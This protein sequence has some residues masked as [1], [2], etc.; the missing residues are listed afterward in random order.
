MR[1]LAASLLVALA[2][3][4]AASAQ[5]PDRPARLAPAPITDASSSRCGSCHEAAYAAWEPS[6]HHRSHTDVLF[7]RELRT[8]R[9]P[10]W[11]SGCHAPL[12]RTPDDGAAREEGVGCSVC[13]VRDGVVLARTVSGRAPH[14]SEVAA[15]DATRACA[16][17]HQFHFAPSS[18]AAIDPALWLQDTVGE[19]AESPFAQRTCASCHLSSQHG[20]PHALPGHTDPSLLAH[21]LRVE[22]TTRRAGRRTE[23]TLALR[24]DVVGHAVPT[25]DLL[26]ELVVS[27]W[28]ALHPDEARAVT[29]GRTLTLTEGTRTDTIPDTRVP[30]SGERVVTLTLAGHPE[31]I[32]W[33]IT[34]R[35][36][37]PGHERARGLPASSTRWRVTSGETDVR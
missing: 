18:A 31:R 19:L 36:L 6:A 14:V 33:E 7:T 16:S 37:P 30:P 35:A 17:C 22:V 27:A 23:V 32:A 11:C 2:C 15:I 1:R 21:A 26:R 10:A 28:P 8:A 24:G 5:A 13:H 20:D 12:A 4:P 34:L 25:G 3:L 9:E 29:L